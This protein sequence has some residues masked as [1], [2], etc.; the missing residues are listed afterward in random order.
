M[1]TSLSM[2]LFDLSVSPS[3]GTSDDLSVTLGHCAQPHERVVQFILSAATVSTHGKY[4]VDQYLQKRFPRAERFV[5]ASFHKHHPRIEQDFL[6]VD[7]MQ[8]QTGDGSRSGSEVKQ[9]SPRGFIDTDDE[10]GGGTVSVMTPARVDLVFRALI[11][12]LPPREDEGKDGEGEPWYP[13]QWKESLHSNSSSSSSSSGSS[14]SSSGGV[15][16]SITL[17][18]CAAIQDIP[19]TMIF[20]NTA[21]KARDLAAAL[22]EYEGGLLAGV[23]AEFHKL[24][25]TYEKQAALERFREQEVTGVKVL[26]CTDAAA[27]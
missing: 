17:A 11:G 19:P 23:V 20:A 1:S 6:H 9:S 3:T 16:D 22:K 4:S 27:R 7:L 5:S 25:P 18:S 15:E 24:V 21:G 13:E 2:L 14:G 26:V 12:A 10:E 8:Q